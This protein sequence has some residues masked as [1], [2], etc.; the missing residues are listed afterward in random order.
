[1]ASVNTNPAPVAALDQ[2]GPQ[3]DAAAAVERL[4]LTFD[5]GRTRPLA[6]RHQ[7]LDALARLLAES[8]DE[9]V[10]ALG[11]DLRKP[12]VEALFTDVNFTAAGVRHLR[13][14]LDRWARPRR[15]HLRLQD[16]P[17]R[18]DVVPEPLGVSLVISPWNYPV[19]LAVSPLAASLAAGNT[20]VVKPSELVPHTSSLLT[21]LLRE[22]LD[23]DAVAVLE[24]GPEVATALLDQQFDHIFFTGSTAVGRIV[25]EAAAR[26]LT[27][28]ILEL[29]GKSP[30]LVADDADLG[31]TAARIAWGKCLNAGQT[32]IA[33]DYVLVTERRRDELVSGLVEAIDRFYGADPAQS[34]DLAAIVNDR[35][36][37]RL[38]GLLVDHGGTLVCGGTS[39]PATRRMAPTVV[40]DPDPASALLGQEIFGP[41]LPVITVDDLDDG[42][43]YVN[44]RPKPLAL[45]VFADDDAAVQRVIDRTSSGG[46]CANHVMFHIGPPELPFGGVGS[47]GWGR[48]HGRA[49]FDALSNLKP[50][51]RRP[52]RPDLSF[53]Y[54]PYT[55][56][57]ARLLSS[58]K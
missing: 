46:V 25:A 40:V 21:R 10:E 48:Y 56:L 28:T 19:Q 44:A 35:H 4:R 51:M 29:G 15:A 1:M 18:G 49:G 58:V 9:L 57:K 27:P 5:R 30:V 32:C 14:N 45:Y 34:P 6:W 42:I 22:H 47:S 16:R 33:P 54:P 12:P 50:V 55:K 11:S 41:I 17:G 31:V 8:A 38:R 52:V 24:G 37:E 39:D 23:P 7:Q 26:H 36:L 13:R 3:A 53:I 43:A 2:L 20:V